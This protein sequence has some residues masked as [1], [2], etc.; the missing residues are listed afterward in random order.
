MQGTVIGIE[1]LK[2]RWAYT[3]ITSSRYGGFYRQRLGAAVVDLADRS[4]R[5]GD[6]PR[7]ELPELAAALE[8]VRPPAFVDLVRRY[9]A[10]RYECVHWRLSQVLNCRTLPQYGTVPFY[11]FLAQPMARDAANEPRRSDPRYVANA[12][13]ESEVSAVA[14]PAIAVVIGKHPIL[15]DGYLRTILWL[16]KPGDALPVWVPAY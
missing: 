10:D 8:A 12:V 1:E 6:L 14:E 3:E 11:T 9:G 4:T 7:S 5:F 13:P 2:A 15:V 16:R